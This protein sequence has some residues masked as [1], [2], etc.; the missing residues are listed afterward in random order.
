MREG[1]KDHRTFGTVFDAAGTGQPGYPL[2]EIFA[3]RRVLIENHKGLRAY[4]TEKVM[5][6]SK[7]GCICVEGR[8]LSI[9]NMTGHQLVICGKILAVHLERGE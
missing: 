5:V 2:I 9:A 1:R 8:S 3:D 6:S 4:G 7:I